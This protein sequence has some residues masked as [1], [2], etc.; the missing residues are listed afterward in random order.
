VCEL[1]TKETAIVSKSL[2][3]IRA[4]LFDFGGTLYD[5]RC[6]EDAER[7]SLCEL[8]R[9]AGSQAADQEVTAAYRAA[10]RQSFH[11]YLPQSYYLHRDLFRDAAVG[12][13]RSLGV[14]ADDETLEEYRRNQWQRHARDFGLHAGVTETLQ[15]LGRR[16][17]HLGIVSNIDDDQ[18]E[19]L[20]AVAKL[21]Q[22]FDAI[23]SSEAAGACKPHPVIFAKALEQ[24]GCRAEE[25]LF[26]GDTLRQDIAGA[27]HAGLRSVL[28]WHR[29]D[30][31]PPSDGPRPEHVIRSI[32]ELL[33]LV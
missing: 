3:R 32:P 33:G 19:H 10:L 26:V 30:R 24:A 14:S 2:P 1:I 12:M 21:R 27:N 23:L 7:E 31:E 17:L 20:L 22:C 11:H 5:Y 13:L 25:A 16:G 28:I 6:L 18:L 15:E 8:A 29:S 4:V 9:A